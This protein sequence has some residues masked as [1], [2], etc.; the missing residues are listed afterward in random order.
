MANDIRR[1]LGSVGA[2]FALTIAAFIAP[3]HADEI[4]VAPTAQQDLGGLGIG[5]NVFWPATAAGLVRFAWAVPAD[6]QT[7]Q[8]AKVVLIPHSPSPGGSG[9]LNVF[10]CAAQ[11]GNLVAASCAGPFPQV[12]ASGV[13]QL[14]EVEI[15]PT[16]A[17]WIGVPGATYLT[18]LAYSTP[19]TATDHIVG[20]RFAY[21]PTPP[22]GVATLGANTFSGAQTAPAFVGDGSGLT[23]LPVPSGVATLGANTFSGTQTAPAFVGSGSGLTNLPFP[24]GAAT[25]GANTF[26]GT[27]TIA[28]GNLELGASTATSGNVTMDGTLFLS[29]HGGG[30]FVGLDAGNLTMT[31]FDN[32]GVGSGALVTNASGNSNTAV[33]ALSL[34]SNDTGSSNTATGAIALLWNTSGHTN[35]ADG[36]GALFFN[37]TGSENTAGG[38]NALSSNSAGSTNTAYGAYSLYENGTGNN[39]IALGYGAGLTNTSGSNN[40][41]VGVNVFGSSPGESNAMYLGNQGTQTK[42]IIAGIRGVTTLTPNAIPVMI[43]SSGQMGTVSSSIRFKEDIHDMN[44]AS[45]RLLNLR[46]VTFR[47]RQAYG[48]GAKPIQYGLIAEEVAEV[49]PELAVRSADGQVET[50][51]YETLNVLLLNE[52]QKQQHRIELLERQHGEQQR[53]QQRIDALE[54][55]FGELLA[56]RTPK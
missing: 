20:L 36:M 24:A 16:L 28:A 53:Q 44:D 30:T 45:R 5:S 51:H 38:A 50:V 52:L 14:R 33:G 54:R 9:T 1:W 42:T 10:V 4:W 48:D 22:A 41:Y 32:S 40:I 6:L 17:S 15:G 35:T 29:S 49:F 27:Q 7:L 13:N 43:D 3:A 11:E 2:A 21:E 26:S 56:E 34:L 18:V 19:T 23:N 37:Q 12:F 55:R 46:P 39:N 47:Y 8:S 25:L 31:G